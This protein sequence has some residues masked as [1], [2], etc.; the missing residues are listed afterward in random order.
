MT[1]TYDIIMVGSGAG[2]GT[3]AL[4][5]A[6]SGKHLLLDEE[7]RRCLR[8]PI[9]LKEHILKSECRQKTS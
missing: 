5:L 7:P 6:P 2:G 9:R 8:R 3:L 1:M 4:K